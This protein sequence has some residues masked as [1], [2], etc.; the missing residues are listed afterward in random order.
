MS[1]FERRF[2]LSLISSGL[3]KDDFVS[4]GNYG[5]KYKVIKN[6]DEYIDLI[7]DDGVFRMPDLKIVFGGR[8]E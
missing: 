7:S 8:N 4:N 6:S 5:I 1:S 3:Y 2:I